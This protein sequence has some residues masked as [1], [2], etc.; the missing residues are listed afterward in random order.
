MRCPLAAAVAFACG[1]CL[2]ACEKPEPSSRSQ[3]RAAASPTPKDELDAG[4]SRLKTK[5]AGAIAAVENYLVGQSPKARKEVRRAEEKFTRD[6]AKWREKL[7][8][9]QKDLQPQ[10]ERLKEQL[11]KLDTGKNRDRL[12]DDLARLQDQSKQTNKLLVE[13]E[14]TGR[15]VWH[16]FKA[17]VTTEEVAHSSPSPTP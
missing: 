1:I 14:A 7:V 4:T 15:D 16:D 13:L 3:A 12:S 2:P 5:A 8:Q 10:I 6:K 9:E 11:G 17:E